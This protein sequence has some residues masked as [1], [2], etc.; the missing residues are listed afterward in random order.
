MECSINRDS[1]ASTNK[2]AKHSPP[3]IRIGSLHARLVNL[4]YTARTDGKPREAGL[5]SLRAGG[6]AQIE[7]LTS[8]THHLHGASNT[9]NQQGHAVT[10]CREYLGPQPF[11]KLM[12]T[13]L[14]STGPVPAKSQ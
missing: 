10:S 4:E 14:G 13:E 1:A 3:P 2:A 11:A 6:M 7:H 9:S 8:C 12:R 5:S